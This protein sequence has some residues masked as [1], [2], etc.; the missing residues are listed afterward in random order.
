VAP[1]HWFEAIA[2]HLGPAY[3][4]YSFT[5]GT[6][7]EVAFL[8]DALALRPGQRLLDVGC[9]PGRHAHAF[10]AAG[11]DVVGVDV[12]ERFL[13]LARAGPGL[14]PVPAPAARVRFVRGDA[15]HLPV[16]TASV[17]A[18]ISLCQGGF[19]LPPVSGAAGPDADADTRILGEI[20]RVLGPGGALALTAFSSY[21]AVRFL[22]QS[23][24]FDADRGV[25]HER[26]AVKDLEGAD[27][28]FDLWTSCYTPRELRLLC[29]AA[30]LDVEHVWAVAPGAYASRPPDVDHPEHLVVARKPIDRVGG[31]PRR[32]RSGPSPLP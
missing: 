20:S 5:K 17:D 24:A 16:A 3:L 2:D 22:E 19:G 32:K 13:R 15:G 11:V 9:G 23:D 18:V 4:R 29:R 21:F 7:Q 31:E 25:N 8:V 1:S 26:T 12:S 14:G 10:A 27:A 28:A 30:G 6:E